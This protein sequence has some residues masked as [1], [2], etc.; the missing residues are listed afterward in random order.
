MRSPALLLLAAVM[1]FI[2][3]I[4]TSGPLLNKTIYQKR[5]PVRGYLDMIDLNTD[6]KRKVEAIRQD[7]LPKADLIRKDLRRKRIVLN[8]LIFASNPDMKAITETTGEISYLQSLL[9][10]EVINHILQEKEILTPAQQ[11]QFQEII[12]KEFEKG[13][14]G[15]HGERGRSDK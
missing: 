14:L 7:F 5:N 12:R 3:G 2:A 11:K 15:I 9:E 10:K 1:I 13:G 6:Q 4:V 8:D